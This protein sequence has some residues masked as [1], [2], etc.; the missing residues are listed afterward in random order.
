MRHLRAGAGESRSSRRQPG[1]GGHVP[2]PHIESPPPHGIL[3]RKR[4]KFLGARRPIVALRRRTL[5]GL[6]FRRR[7]ARRAAP[8]NHDAMSA[9]ENVTELNKKVELLI[10]TQCG[11]C[12]EPLPED[13][14]EAVFKEM[15]GRFSDAFGGFSVTRIQGGWKMPDGTLAEE[16]VDVLWSKATAQGIEEHAEDVRLWA[17]EVADRLSQDAVALVINDS[18]AF[19]PRSNPKAP[20]VHKAAGKVAP[21]VGA[22]QAAVKAAS[23]SRPI[24]RL[25]AIQSILSRFE[26][27]ADARALFCGTLGYTYANAPL[28]TTKWSDSLRQMLRGQPQIISDTNGFRIVHLRLSADRLLRSAERAVINRIL[29]DDPSFHGLFVVS[30]GRQQ[31]WRLVNAKQE[32]NDSSRFLL[33]R[34]TVGPG[35]G[36]RTATERLSQID[37]ES[38]SELTASAIQQLHDQAFDVEAVTKQ[39]FTEIANWYFWALKHAQ[40]PAHAPKEAD[41][42]DHIS[43][44]RLITRLIFCWFIK[45]KG[46][47]SEDLFDHKQLENT[48]NGFAPEKASNKDSVFY[49]AILQNLFFATL[50]TEMDKRAWAKEDQNFMAHSLYRYRECFRNPASALGLFKSIPFLNG[51]L[52][53]CLDKDLGEGFRPRY[54]RI[55]GFSRRDDSQSTVPDFLFF[56]PERLVDLGKDY[57]DDSFEQVKVRGLI[58][59]L[60][61]YNFTIEEN[62]PIDQEVAL[63]PELAGKVFENLL[64][65]YNPE[66]GATARKETGSFYTRREIVDFMVEEALIAYLE[67][68]LKAAAPTAKDV[69]ARLR[70]LFAYNY[71]PH[72][73]SPSEVDILIEAI[74]TVKVIDPAV[75]SGAFPM[76]ILH[77]L[78]FI[79]GKLDPGNQKWKAK[80]LRKAAEIPDSTVRE[81]VLEDIEQSFSHNELD[82]GRKLYLIENCIYG[83]DI[84][85]IAVQIAKMRFFI[86]LIAD[87]KVDH[88]AP[89]LGVRALPNLETQFVAANS[90]IPVNR[91]G[92]QMLRN[93]DIDAKEA[94]LRRVRER[95][96]MSRTLASKAK[97]R[98]QDARLR[99]EIANLLQSDGWDSSTALMLATWDPYDQNT[100][101]TFFDPEWMFGITEGFD[102][103]LG[104][105]PYVGKQALQKQQPDFAAFARRHFIS[106]K[107]RDFDLFGLFIEH[108]ISLVRHSG[109]VCFIV[110]TG[111]YTGPGFSALRRYVLLHSDPVSFVNLPYDMFEEAWVDTTVFHTRRRST[112]IQWPRLDHCSVWLKTFGK[113]VRIQDKA[114]FHAGRHVVD[115][116][117]WLRDGGDE[118]LTRS[119]SQVLA[120]LKKMRMNSVPLGQCADVQR[121]VT[122]FSLSDNPEHKNSRLA[123]DGTI[124]R[125]VVDRGPKRYIRFDDSLAELKPARY[126]EGG[127]ILLR[128]L[129][130]RQMRLQACIVEEDFV[131]NKSMQSLLPLPKGP[132]LHLLL[133]V[134]NSRLL[135]WYFLQRSNVAHRDDFPK[136]VLKETRELPISSTAVTSNAE[137]A[138]HVEEIIEAVRT[139]LKAKQKT[140]ASDTA[141]LELEVDK[142][143]Y[144]LY[145]LTKE[146]IKLVEESSGGS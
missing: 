90:L 35:R 63:D 131:T 82:Y 84:Q 29:R 92:Q 112:M 109:S 71:E 81:K 17:V 2:A 13:V 102:V 61:H 118:F 64:A 34:I 74:D 57:G 18:M 20:C 126:F 6:A 108:S 125:Y 14:R 129:I 39:F 33:R 1:G 21:S 139:I 96:F 62:T 36:V 97:C 77:K 73:V 75:G 45:E 136:I 53:E 119:N 4:L 70:H 111:W 24:D 15:K 23:R 95:H 8:P 107:G 120:L 32:A 27:L 133:G 16:P 140:A 49:R 51:G 66:T 31:Q 68:R 85:P 28:P 76:G 121:G 67:M 7:R 146:E 122:P 79:L 78:V 65:A 103:A 38:R 106:A 43:V 30:D 113:R 26:S 48:L 55:D 132:D 86:S 10:P 110:P 37:L 5:A 40:F 141:Q 101:A 134:V 41:G 80:Q 11:V 54:I 89:N 145:G 46:L 116:L 72:L 135:S 44:I 114:D 105:P 60:R 99:A 93:R 19:F 87:Q 130:S 127:R 100:S 12:R 52:F 22:M 144:A 143:V 50:N 115:I 59:T 137:S 83:V 25:Y 104:N 3:M 91:P 47:L 58:H 56:G 42:K 88:T 98:E 117:E 9:S 69:E 124:R 138:H 142:N 94:E 128:E 123:F